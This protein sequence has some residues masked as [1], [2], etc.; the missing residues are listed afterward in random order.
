MKVTFL[1]NLVNHHQIPLADELYKLLGNEYTYIALEELP[2]WL[3]KGG[4]QE[5]ERP[6]ILR[7]YKN[8]TL[9]QKAKDLIDNSDVVIVGAA[10]E[11]YVKNR[12]KA[13]KITF[14][15]S[16]R[17]FRTRPWYLH[18]PRAWKHFY[19]NHIRN[20]NKRLYVLAASAYTANDVY[21][22]GAYKNKVYKWGYF[23]KVEE[24]DIDKAIL[25]KRGNKLR[26]L[27][28]ARFLTLKHPELPVILAKRLKDEG[29]SFEINMYGNGIELKNT[30][31]LIEKLNV[32]DVVFLKGN[33][34]NEEILKEM[35]TH[36][37][38]LFTSD[39]REG[40]GAVLN[41]SMSNGC[42]VVA[43]Q[44]IGAAP[45]LIKDG[46]NGLLFKSGD[47]N[48]LYNQVKKIIDDEGYREILSKNA[49][50]I[51]YHKWNPRIVAERFITLINNI[52]NG[53]DTIYTDG[54]CSKAYP[55]RN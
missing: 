31:K 10:P 3:K 24:F 30:Q 53:N 29:Y 36:H 5:I 28:C 52:I 18:S 41:E 38:F 6:Y 17:W 14:R 7:L 45:F 25:L 1:T 42:A 19:T 54:P 43:S 21:A 32:A 16:E 37:I 8:D 27:W 13:N 23:T 47:I 51:M 26:I 48:S 22:I 20:K 35:R 4:Y 33:L 2:E 11:D 39:K 34:P 49:Y 9:V 44:E 15:Y 55:H 50:N 40:W 46:E 12:I